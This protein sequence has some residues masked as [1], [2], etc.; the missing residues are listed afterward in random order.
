V[1]GNEWW[2]L[3]SAYLDDRLE[4]AKRAEFEERLKSDAALRAEVMFQRRIKN[5][6]QRLP[7]VEILNDNFKSHL[8]RRVDKELIPVKR[9][10]RLNYATVTLS[11]ILVSFLFGGIALGITGL[12][13]WLDRTEKYI[14]SVERTVGPQNRLASPGVSGGVKNQILEASARQKVLFEVVGVAP[15]EFF[16]RV[17]SSYAS[18]EAVRDVVA[19]FFNQTTIF[20]GATVNPPGGASLP[21][22]QNLLRFAGSLPTEVHLVI[23][24]SKYD[25]FRDFMARQEGVIPPTI[26][27]SATNNIQE[28]GNIAVDIRFKS[29]ESR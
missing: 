9:N 2:Q 11:V 25:R 23:P 8:L 7:K 22:Q 13:N 29:F 20:D 1:V 6:L 5:Y 24:S 15:E 27:M 4:P 21:G 14:V 26:F 10:Y 19:P 12:V 28:A 17:L 16:S 18:G 3:I